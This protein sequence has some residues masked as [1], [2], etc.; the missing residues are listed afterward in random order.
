[1]A[2]RTGRGSGGR[3]LERVLVEVGPAL[4]WE[5]RADLAAAVRTEIERRGTVVRPARLPVISAIRRPAA[6]SIRLFPQAS[7][8]TAVAVAAAVVVLATGVLAISPS[9]RHAV[10]GWL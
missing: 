10:A 4:A 2:R 9:A 1:M 3:E 7:W 6:R 5:D 8:P